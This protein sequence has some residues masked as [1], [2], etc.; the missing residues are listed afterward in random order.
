[1]STI[2]NEPQSFVKTNE[3]YGTSNEEDEEVG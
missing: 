3:R 2:M 1:M